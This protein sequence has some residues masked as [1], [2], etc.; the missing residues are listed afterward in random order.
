[1]PR[2]A[3]IISPEHT[4]HVTHRGNDRQAIFHEASD[5]HLYL[6]LLA[7]AQRKY[8]FDL[9]HYALMP[10]H[11]HLIM[12]SRTRSTISPIMQMVAQK[13][14]R[15]YNANYGKTGHLWGD[16]YFSK[17]VENDEYLLTAGIYVELNPVRANIVEHPSS[18]RWSS[19]SFYADGKKET[20]LT[21]SPAF[22][23][24]HRAAE[25]RRKTYIELARVFGGMKKR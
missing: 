5:Y 20:L 13:Y 14:A 10:N 23:G 12:R 24:I 7:Q 22:L 2:Q 21:P 9:F 1:M 4:Y 15:K 11:V 25:H 19:H 3:R 17:H 18:Y 6:D 16:R 8:P